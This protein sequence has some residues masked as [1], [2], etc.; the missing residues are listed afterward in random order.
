ML[1]C[2]VWCVEVQRCRNSLV[3]ET[4]ILAVFQITSRQRSN[5]MAIER[6]L[7]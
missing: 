6:S 3:H 2:G 1:R 7:H 4:L 5:C